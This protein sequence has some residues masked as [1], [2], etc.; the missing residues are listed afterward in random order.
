MSLQRLKEALRSGC[1]PSQASD[2]ANC[3]KGGGGTTTVQNADPWVGAQ[4]FLRDYMRQAKAQSRTPMKY[5]GGQTIAGFAPEQEQAFNRMMGD[6][7]QPSLDY[8]GGI[9]GGENMDA[10][11]NPIVNQVN[12]QFSAA[13]R[14]GSGSH[15][16]ALGKGITEAITPYQMQAAQL[17]PQL[18]AQ[19]TAGIMGVGDMRRAFDQAMLDEARNKFNFY[20]N[21]PIQRLQQYASLVSPGAGF[22]GQS[23]MTQPGGSSFASALGGGLT[24]A[25]FGSMVP[26]FGGSLLTGGGGA[27]LGPAGWIGA[28][29]GALGGLL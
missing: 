22:G 19:K 18:E 12:S 11:T 16:A 2:A 13:G 15:N 5:Y 23:S 1:S 26:G 25:A 21:E 17:L 29:L 6:T 7:Y 14:Y 9:L 8:Y 27:L 3:Y 20:Q 24:G 10:I 28:G 4:P